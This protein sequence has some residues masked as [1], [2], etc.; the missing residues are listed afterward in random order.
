MEQSTDTTPGLR[1]RMAEV[2]NTTLVTPDGDIERS[3]SKFD[4]HDR[5]NFLYNCAVCQGNV[6]AIVAAISAVQDEEMA[7]L[8][9]DLEMV[10]R[11]VN[12]DSEDLA[13]ALAERDAL[14]AAIEDVQTCWPDPFGNWSAK[15]AHAGRAVKEHMLRKLNAALATT[16]G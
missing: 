13:K 9:T 16:E 10:T 3:D 4:R 1:E 8:R 5:H 6:A 12:R 14:K 11:R 2:L 7:R 15:E